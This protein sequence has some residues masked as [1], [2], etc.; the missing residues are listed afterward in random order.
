MP[1]MRD[2]R[3]PQYSLCFRV[4]AGESSW[5]QTEPTW[6]IWGVPNKTL[7]LLP[8]DMSG[9]RAVELGCGTGYVSAW[10]RR[11][12]AEFVCVP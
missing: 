11:R 9:L 5:A 2:A 8:D 7:S 4:C 3:S 1:F 12:G 10:M 6:G